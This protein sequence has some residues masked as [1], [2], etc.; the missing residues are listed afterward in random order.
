[1]AI[2]CWDAW[3]CLLRTLVGEVL[4]PAGGCREGPGGALALVRG[5]HA[6]EDHACIQRQNTRG[7]SSCRRRQGGV[8]Y[9]SLKPQNFHPTG[10]TTPCAHQNPSFPHPLASR[11]DRDL[12]CGKGWAGRGGFTAGTTHPGG[13]PT[14]SFADDFGNGGGE[15]PDAIGALLSVV[16]VPLPPPVGMLLQDL[17]G[18]EED[19]AGT[20]QRWGQGT[21]SGEQP[22]RDDI[23]CPDIESSRIVEVPKILQSSD[24]QDS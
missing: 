15:V 17:R 18:D 5:C 7:Q 16:D 20:R 10:H 11:G 21:G 12:S 1:M 24:L 4:Q 2:G 3:G 19:R 6:G 13:P 9:L 23:S 22:H 14:C 8:R